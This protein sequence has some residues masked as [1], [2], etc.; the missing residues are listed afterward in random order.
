MAKKNVK[1]RLS[2]WGRGCGYLNTAHTWAKHTVHLVNCYINMI[3]DCQ[4]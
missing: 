3:D 2:E 1:E 4:L